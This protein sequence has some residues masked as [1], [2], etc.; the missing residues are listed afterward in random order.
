MRREH[1]NSSA[2]SRLLAWI[3]LGL[4]ASATL[5]SAWIAFVNFNRIGV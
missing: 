1:E 2:L 4:M 3:V 5:Y